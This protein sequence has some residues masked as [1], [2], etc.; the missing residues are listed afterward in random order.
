MKNKLSLSD[1]ILK[2]LRNRNEFVNGGTLEKMAMSAGYK[3]STAS[4]ICRLLTERGLLERK[5][6]GQ[7]VRSVW[8]RALPPKR[9]EPVFSNGILILEKKIYE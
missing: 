2:Y 3:G 6:E 4:R 1:R 8:Y 9:I 5:E 7:R